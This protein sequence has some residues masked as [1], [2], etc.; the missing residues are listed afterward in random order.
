MNREG[1]RLLM[2]VAGAVALVF[3]IACGNA[4]GL[5]L[6]R[7]LQR[8]HEY[9]VRAALGARRLQLCRPILAESLLLALLGGGIVGAGLAAGLC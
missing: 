9:A 4:A 2:P 8:Q 6:A 3:L 7:G 5:L 1:R